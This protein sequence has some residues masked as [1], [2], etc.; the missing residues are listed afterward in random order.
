MGRSA[1]AH[2]LELA[3]EEQQAGH[4]L[5]ALRRKQKASRLIFRIAPSRSG[6]VSALRDASGQILI[7]GEAIA[8]EICRHWSLVFTS[9]EVDKAKLDE[10]LNDDIL[11]LLHGSN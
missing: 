1:A 4:D 8:Q 7:E 9:Q 5:V 6:S 2:E 3:G 10:W 11:Q